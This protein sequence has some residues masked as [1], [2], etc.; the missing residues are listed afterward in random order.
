MGSNKQSS[1]YYGVFNCKINSVYS[2]L[3]DHSAFPEESVIYFSNRFFFWL[4][5]FTKCSY[6]DDEFAQLP[7]NDRCPPLKSYYYRHRLSWSNFQVELPSSECFLVSLPWLLSGAPSFQSYVEGG[8]G[9]PR[10]VNFTFAVSTFHVVMM[11]VTMMKVTAHE[12]TGRGALYNLI[13]YHR[14]MRLAW[15]HR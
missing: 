9:L 10:K 15:C 4:P 8:G 2:R 7:V 1:A 12:M 5:R 13:W 11:R 14:D 3:T 6:I